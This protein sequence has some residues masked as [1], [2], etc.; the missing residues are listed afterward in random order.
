MS[1]LYLITRR[2]LAA[3]LAAAQIAHAIVEWTTTRPPE[4]VERWRIESNTVVVCTVED[5]RELATL[6]ELTSEDAIG[7]RDPDIKNEL[8]AIALL[9]SNRAKKLCR[10]LRLFLA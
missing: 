3:G 9:P 2:D 10:N 1:K 4:E 5:E 8:T 6:S 7:F